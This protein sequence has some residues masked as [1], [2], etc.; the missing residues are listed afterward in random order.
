MEKRLDS[1]GNHV[2]WT[3]VR[4]DELTPSLQYDVLWGDGCG[5]P[6]DRPRNSA[7]AAMRLYDLNFAKTRVIGFGNLALGTAR[8][9]I[10]RKR[11]GA[12]W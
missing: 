7:H 9:F 12:G 11:V 1:K 6:M 4:W 3:K 8:P 2:A 10:E 5:R